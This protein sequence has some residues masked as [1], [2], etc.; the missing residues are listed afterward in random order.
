MWRVDNSWGKK[1]G[2][3]GRL[4]ITDSYFSEYVYEIVIPKK[5][6]YSFDKKFKDINMSKKNTII[7]PPWDIFGSVAT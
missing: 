3:D 2:K 5:I 7:L 4:I 1:L 6:A